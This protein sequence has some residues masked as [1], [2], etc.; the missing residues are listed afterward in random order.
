M[1]GLIARTL[2]WLAVL[3][4]LTGAALARDII[5]Y[6][7]HLKPPFIVNAKAEQGLDFDIANYLN[8]KQS[9]FHFR[10]VFMPRNRLNAMI[11]ASKL[12]GLIIGVN[13]LWFHDP[14]RTRFLWS[15]PYMPDQDIVVSLKTKPVDYTG[16]ESLTGLT[17]GF[18]QGYY[19]YGLSELADANKLKREYGLSEESNLG[20]LALRRFDVTVVSRSTYQ[21][22]LKVNPRWR[23]LFFVAKTPEER[24][25][26]HFLIPKQMRDVQLELN[27]ILRQ[28]PHDR[29]WH[30]ILQKYH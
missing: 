9:K 3:L 17:V 29:D 7:Y 1:F 26:R 14:K 13:E 19:Y 10:T 23:T 21:Y 24:F 16:P 2:T 8:R 30:E 20:M 5:I 6:D 12:D 18:P 15:P 27:R 11:A 25:E 28:L 4:G 22:L